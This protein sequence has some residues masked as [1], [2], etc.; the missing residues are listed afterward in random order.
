MASQCSPTDSVAVLVVE[1]HE[2]VRECV[3]TLLSQQ[4]DI[5]VIGSVGS[6]EEAIELLRE[7]KPNVVVMDLGLPGI[8]GI[9]ATRRV[10]KDNPDVRVI[11]L[12]MYADAHYLTDMLDAGAAGYVLKQSAVNDLVRAL[13]IATSKHGSS[14]GPASSSVPSAFIRPSP[15]LSPKET[16]TEREKDILTLVGQ[17][18]TSKEIGRKLSLSTKTVKNYRARIL[19]KLRTRNCPEAVSKAVAQGIIRPLS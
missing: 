2:I 14:P 17:G 15:K 3:C 10:T 5:H 19:Q 9:E 11:A 8:S 6:G 4:P 16:L 12:T 18:C 1:D 7:V 13:R